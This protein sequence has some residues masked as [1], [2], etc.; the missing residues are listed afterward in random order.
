LVVQIWGLYAFLQ[1]EA[2]LFD[3]LIFEDHEIHKHY[4]SELKARR[5]NQDEKPIIVECVYDESLTSPILKSFNAYRQ[6]QRD[7]DWPLNEMK[8]GEWVSN[9]SELDDSGQQGGWKIERERND[10]DRPNAVRVAK[11]ILRSIA[12]PFSEEQLIKGLTE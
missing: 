2:V 12:N 5:Q 7:A 11:D 3:C 6:K 4:L 1:N 9:L 8:I 10:K